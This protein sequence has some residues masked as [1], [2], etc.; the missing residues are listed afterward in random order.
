MT[1]PAEA[2]DVAKNTTGTGI[3]SFNGTSSA[4]PHVAGTMAL[5]KQL[6]P[7]WTVEQLKALIMNTADHDLFV[8]IGESGTKVGPGRIGKR[9]HRPDARQHGQRP[10]RTT[11]MVPA[12][13]AFRT[14]QWTWPLTAASR[15]TSRRS[16]S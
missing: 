15:L 10:S 6:H 8:N 1:A 3:Q 12:R 16:M 2:V 14:D 5:L 7:T 4:T 13:S 11:P 9:S